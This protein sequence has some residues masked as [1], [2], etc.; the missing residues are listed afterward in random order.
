MSAYSKIYTLNATPNWVWIT[1]YDIGE[2]T[3][4][5]YGWVGPNAGREWAS[6]N[7][8]WGSF[9]KVRAEVKDLPGPETPT[10]F[11]TK[12]QINP[13]SSS[14]A[15][16]LLWNIYTAGLGQAGDMKWTQEVDG[17][18]NAVRLTGDSPRQFWWETS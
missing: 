12:V 17:S 1:I 8:C 16:F 14:F 6:G 4:L 5:D 15:G 2:T 11:D 13:Q 10:I 7:Y 18:G 3:H 9:Y